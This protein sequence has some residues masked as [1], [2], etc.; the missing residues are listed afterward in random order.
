MTFVATCK[1][2]AKTGVT[3][4]AATG[5][6]TVRTTLS[7]WIPMPGKAAITLLGLVTTLV[8]ICSRMI[9]TSCGAYEIVE[10]PM[11]S[12]HM[13]PQDTVYPLMRTQG[14]RVSQVSMNMIPGLEAAGPTDCTQEFPQEVGFGSTEL[15]SGLWTLIEH[16]I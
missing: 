8:I 3:R 9:T 10:T 6:T 5:A 12:T 7:N 1:T 13:Q 11:G 15:L 14:A 16:Q 2:S 4:C